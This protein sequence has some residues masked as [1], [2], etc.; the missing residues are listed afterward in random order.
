MSFYYQCN[1]KICKNEKLEWLNLRSSQG[2]LQLDCTKTL[3]KFVFRETSITTTRYF[4]FQQFEN[5]FFYN[6]Y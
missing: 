5:K 4:T 1:D 6:G 2:K 3:P